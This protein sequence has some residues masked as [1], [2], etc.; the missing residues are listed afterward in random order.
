MTFSPTVLKL[1]SRFN[2]QTIAGNISANRSGSAAMLK[3]SGYNTYGTNLLFTPPRRMGGTPQYMSSGAISRAMNGQNMRFVSGGIPAYSGVSYNQNVTMGTSSAFNTGMGIGA[4]LNLAMQ[5]AGGLKE[6]GLFGSKEAV[7]PQGA[8]DRLT[9]QID[10]FSNTA[11]TVT[12]GNFTSSLSGAKSFAEVNKIENEI[13]Q[14]K[15][16]INTDYKEIGTTASKNVDDILSGENVNEGLQLAQ[17]QIDKSAFELSELSPEDLEGSIKTIDSDINKIGELKTTT[18]QQ[19]KVKVSEKSGQISGTLTVKNGELERNK[20]NL[21]TLQSTNKDGCNDA[22]IAE[23]QQQINKLENDEIPKLEEQKKQLE[24]AEKAIGEITTEAGNTI[25][26]LNKKKAE[27][28]DIK[29]AEDGMKD[30]KYDLA[31][32]QDEEL[33]KT[34]QQLDKLN[35]EIE[36]LAKSDKSPDQYDKK[37]EQRSQ[38]LSGLI[39]QRTK[40]YTTL[41]S[42]VSSLSSAGE[43]SFKNSKNQTYTIKNL[44][45]ANNMITSKPADPAPGTKQSQGSPPPSNNGGSGGIPEEDPNRRMMA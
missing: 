39:T 5:L 41:G 29:Q 2:A 18:L 23:L 24:A 7:K 34:M 3:G 22:K 11:T 33:G 4:T 44:E 45:K 16:N 37:D 21:S 6:L 32:S 15:A 8:G 25:E 1:N 38:K 28:K 35:K 42:F 27:I 13:T 36:N 40:L 10:A 14:K 19:A 43:T 12:S 30:K 9:S 20:A 31:K 26:S 17:V